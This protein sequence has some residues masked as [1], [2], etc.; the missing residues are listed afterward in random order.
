MHSYSS[1]R[2]NTD[3][4]LLSLFYNDSSFFSLYL[5]RDLAVLCVSVLFLR[6][7]KF[8]S[9]AI[10]IYANDWL[11]FFNLTFFIATVHP[12]HFT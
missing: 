1:Q 4:H 9:N 2:P 6:M 12:K 5:T 11:F 3:K 10:R 8:R 7:A